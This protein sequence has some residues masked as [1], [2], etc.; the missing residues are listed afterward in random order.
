MI[1][2]I[3][4]LLGL[5]LQNPVENDS[6]IEFSIFFEINEIKFWIQWKKVS[7]NNIIMVNFDRITLS[8]PPCTLQLAK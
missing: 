8:W 4:D 7:F 2:K 3:Y 6:I 5:H 1:W